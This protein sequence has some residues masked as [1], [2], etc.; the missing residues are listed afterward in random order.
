MRYLCAVLFSISLFGCSVVSYENANVSREYEFTPH[1]IKGGTYAIVPISMNA[2]SGL[3]A[4]VISA[5][6]EKRGMVP[7]QGKGAADFILYLDYV[8]V[9]GHNNDFPNYPDKVSIGFEQTCE[10][11][12]ICRE[13]LCGAPESFL[14]RKISGVVSTFMFK[15][16][17]YKNL[18]AG[19]KMDKI[20]DGS[21]YVYTTSGS[22]DRYLCV[23]R[24]LFQEF[25]GKTDSF[26]VMIPKTD[27]DQMDISADS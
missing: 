10:N 24:Y 17:M 19:G 23:M 4:D 21:A 1:D 14:D 20:F 18:H 26:S 5:Y 16:A 12:K 25:P 27:C 2:N 13:P 9:P 6:L 15:A 7:F 22:A 8:V 3:Y 11:C